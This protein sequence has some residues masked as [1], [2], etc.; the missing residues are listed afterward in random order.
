MPPCEQGVWNTGLAS[1]QPDENMLRVVTVH[2]YYQQPGGENVSFEAEAALLEDRGHRVARFC[3]HNDRITAS[4]E[5]LAA[6]AAVWNHSAY[7]GVRRLVQETGAAVC[8]F[9]NTFPL[10]S[11]AAYYGAKASNAA[12]VQK[13]SNFRLLCP[14]ANL[15]RNGSPCEDCVGRIAPWPGVR[16]RCYRGSVLASA[17]VATM[18]TVHRIL[19]TWS[20]CVDAYIALTEFG[21]QKLIEGGLPAS[22]IHVKPNFL[23]RDPGQGTSRG[24]YALY[25]GRLSPEKGIETLLAAWRSARPGLTLRIVGD[26][27]DSTYVRVIRRDEDGVE[28]LGWLS[29]ERTMEQMKCAE[30]LVVPSVCYETFGLV[31]IEAYATGA[32]VI[33]SR[34]GALQSIVDDKRTGLLFEAGNAQDLASKIDWLL[35]HPAPVAE[36]RLEARREYEEKYTAD[37]NYRRLIE[38]YDAA[39][40][41][42]RTRN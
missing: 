41:H 17:S 28:W 25:V 5:I 11:P 40:R 18:L 20:Q 15:L 39:V 24:N 7:R 31:V 34:L 37:V 32:P 33:A 3:M 10:L 16:H 2:N 35:T 4:N 38:I 42:A 14:G 27:R 36:M 13:V 21:K 12:I 29:R 8:H 22:R 19:R 26:S 1:G 9:H 6:A 23:Y 30:F